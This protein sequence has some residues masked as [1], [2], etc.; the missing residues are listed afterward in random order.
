MGYRDNKPEP[1]RLF[2]INSGQLVSRD[3]VI[4]RQSDVR[5]T[6]RP[7]VRIGPARRD[8]N[9]R[10][11]PPPWTSNLPL[12]PQ[13]WWTSGRYPTC[14]GHFVLAIVRVESYP[15]SVVRPTWP[16]MCPLYS[17]QRTLH[18][19]YSH[20][21]LVLIPAPGPNISLSLS[22]WGRSFV[23][24]RPI[25]VLTTARLREWASESERPTT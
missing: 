23:S 22:P 17:A 13:F 21:S 11:R 2:R 16:I 3:R 8:S 1:G 20:D 6:K 5:Y 10:D 15:R 9:H 24:C 14:W 7:H 25:L 18:P 12:Q 19:A 4:G